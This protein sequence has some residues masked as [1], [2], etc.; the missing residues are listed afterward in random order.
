MKRVYSVEPADK[1]SYTTQFDRFYTW[2]APLYDRLITRLPLWHAWVTP[3]IPHVRGPRVLEVSF[4]TGHLLTH[5]AQRYE[6]YGIDYNR[7]MTQIA[8]AN[9]AR[10]GVAARLLVGNVETLPF[11]GE[12]FDTV[13]NTMAFSGY[14]DAQQALSELRRV[15]RRGGRLLMI[16]A[17]FPANGNW[18]GM[19]LARMVAASG[20]LLRDM[21]A[22]FRQY[23][24]A[25]TDTEIGG[26][27]SIHLYV[28]TKL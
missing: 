20:D 13:V 5:Y 8:R 21:A 19:A 23:S 25:H 10:Q 7:R 6:T 3:V 4:G 15:L 11:A 28:A 16:D 12:M 27:G 22:L 18:R 24:F 9:L 14:P 1:H 26:W 17:N 2:F